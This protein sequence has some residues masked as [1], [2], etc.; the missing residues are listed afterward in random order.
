MHILGKYISNNLVEHIFIP[1]FPNDILQE[2]LMQ[3]LMEPTLAVKSLDI[4]VIERDDVINDFRVLLS[5]HK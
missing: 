2:H 1:N 5:I 3:K 4:D